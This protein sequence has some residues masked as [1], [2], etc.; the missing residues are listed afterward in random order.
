MKKRQ[1]RDGEMSDECEHEMRKENQFAH[2]G[3]DCPVCHARVPHWIPR[4]QITYSV[5]ESE[6]IAKRTRSYARGQSLEAVMGHIANDLDY[7]VDEFRKRNEQ[8]R[9]AELERCLQIVRKVRGHYTDIILR[10]HPDSTNSSEARWAVAVCD[11]IRDEIAKRTDNQLSALLPEDFRDIAK[12]DKDG[13]K[14]SIENAEAVRIELESCS[15]SEAGH[16][17]EPVPLDEN[18]PTFLNMA[19]TFAIDALYTDG[20]HHKQWYLEKILELLSVNLK[21][22]RIEQ[23]EWTKGIEP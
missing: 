22:V 4:P 13:H 2:E 14:V 8:V 11:R 20:A 21:A 7:I 18:R 19:R 12:Y 1:R 16:Q 3:W 10:S 17:K 6:D 9:E 15:C 23:G 5:Q